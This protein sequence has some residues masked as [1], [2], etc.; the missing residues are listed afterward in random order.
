M[1]Q[2]AVPDPPP[3]DRY[4]VLRL[5]S[6]R[7]FVAGRF[8]AALGQ[9]ML[10]VAVGWELYERTGSP[11]AL[12]LVGLAGIVP[13]LMFT[14]PAGHVADQQDRRQIIVG[15]QCL[16]AVAS[17]GLLLVS[18][19]HA[20]VGW[21][22]ACL[23]LSG[24]ARAFLWPASGAF[25]PRIVPRAMLARAVAWN[26]GSFQLSSALG[27]AV[28]GLLIA[29]TGRAWPVYAFNV[30]AGLGC[31]GLVVGVEEHP[32]HAEPVGSEPRERQPMSLASLGAGIGFVFRHPLILSTITLDLFAV[33]L[34]GATALLPVYCKDILHV[35]PERLGFLQAALPVGSVSMALLLAHRQPM[36][37]AGRTLLWAVAGFGVATVV[38]GFSRVY[39]LSW[40]ALCACGAMDNVSVVVRHTLIPLLTPDAMRGRVA[41]VN[42]IFISASNELGSL[43]SGFVA[44]LFGPVAAVVSGGVG[45]VLVVGV[46]AL[47][48]PALRRFGRLD[49]GGLAGHA[50]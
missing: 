46:V 3:P 31:A 2:V 17:V 4:A 50:A 26:S 32:E 23:A 37:R 9:Q 10:G 20:P 33:L 38:F 24:T 30:L 22:Y 16:V 6:F 11:L 8:V 18:A 44:N 47:L 40:L 25:L 21:T 7:R 35:G 1:P 12:G 39:A 48:W 5:R 14:L 45:T 34:G 41:S 43:E 29:W 13:M 27:P 28:G 19:T 42:S 36:R 15:T 49:E